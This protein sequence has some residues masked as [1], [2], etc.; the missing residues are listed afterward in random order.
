MKLTQLHEAFINKANRPMSFGALPVVPMEGGDVPVVAV[1]KWMRSDGRLRKEYNFQTSATRSEF[2]HKLLE[3]ED[4][5]GHHGTIVVE[6]KRVILELSTK[7]GAGHVTE[8]DKEYAKE[9][10][11]IFREVVYK[12]K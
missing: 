9:A 4:T 10:D 7:A 11:L 6:E 3:H 1:N 8:L 2:V 5:V 12:S